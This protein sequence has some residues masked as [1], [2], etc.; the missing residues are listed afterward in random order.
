MGDI[1][2]GFHKNNHFKKLLCLITMAYVALIASNAFAAT[3]L[4]PNKGDTVWVLTSTILVLMMSIPGIALF[5]GGLV[6]AKNMLSTLMQV[7]AVTA[8]GMLVWAFWGY[9]L[10]FSSGNAFIGG[11]SKIFMMNMSIDTLAET[12]TPNVVLPEFV[13]FSFQMT[14]ACITTAVVLGALAERMK[15]AAVCLF[16]VLWPLFS[17]YPIAHMAWFWGGATSVIGQTPE[18]I[19]DGAGL[20]F[21]WGLLDFAGGTVVEINSGISALVGCLI[22][23]ARDSYRNEPIAPHSLTLAFVGAGMLWIGWFGFN[24]GSSLEANKIAGLATVNTLLATAAAGISWAAYEWIVQK[25]PSMLGFISGVIAGLVVI[26]PG[27]G[28]VGPMGALVLGLIIS[29]ICVFFCAKVKMLFKYDDSLDAFGIHG[30]AGIVGTLATGILVAPSL[31]GTGLTDFNNC[32]AA[33]CAVLEYNML[34]QFIIQ[35]KAVCVTIVWA[36]VASFIVFNII[37][38]TIGLRASSDVQEEGLDIAEHGERAYHN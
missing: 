37:K 5:Y 31:G 17:Y 1:V 7:S 25:R 23:G 28:F 6:R 38:Y 18:Q 27:A 33:G 10:S 36:G 32:T 14:F 11:F 4:V 15:F 2:L 13:W 8:I 3:P 21:K 20:F 24:A 26:T 16:A 34:S 19:A 30:I 35:L 12:F 9:S 29:P 22:L